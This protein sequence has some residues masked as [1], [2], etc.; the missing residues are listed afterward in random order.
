ML[1]V[2]RADSLHCEHAIPCIF[3][4][5]LFWFVSAQQEAALER[6]L[7]IC[8]AVTGEVDRIVEWQIFQNNIYWL[9][10]V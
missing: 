10:L 5:A 9:Q 1:R 4:K 3:T 7:G 8:V 6:A 2:Y